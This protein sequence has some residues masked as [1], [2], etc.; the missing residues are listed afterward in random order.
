VT[1]SDMGTSRSRARVARAAVVWV[2]S[3]IW[4]GLALWCARSYWE[5]D[6]VYWVSVRST[7]AG[8]RG[9]SNGARS[10]HGTLILERVTFLFYPGVQ[11]PPTRSMYWAHQPTGSARASN[12]RYGPPLLRWVGLG[13]W[14]SGGAN[15]SGTY[16]NRSLVVP[17]WLPLLVTGAL[18]G[19]V[20][21]GRARRRFRPQ[22]ILGRCFRCGYDL[23][24]NTSWVCPECGSG[25]KVEAIRGQSRRR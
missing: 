22:P 9:T 3:A 2:S 20:I 12:L 5:R 23:T 14:N 1:T 7:V 13:K 8:W 10:V 15:P 18:P 21:L 25:V 6:N 17:F 4:V 11:P 24:G 16:D 19:W